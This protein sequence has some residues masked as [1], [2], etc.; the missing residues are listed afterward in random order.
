M[1]F[2]SV[3][4]II[5]ALYM[6]VTIYAGLAAKKYVENSDGYFVA[7][8]K[9]KLSLGIASLIASEIGIVTFMYFAEF[10]FTM[11]FSS[12]F[13]GF[14]SMI[15]F[16][17]IGYSGFIVKRLRQLRIM[18]VPE[19]YEIK[20]DKKVRLLGGVILFFSGILNMG[21]F[22][23]FD[24]LFLSEAMGLGP[25]A[26]ILIM[27]LM[28]VIVIAYTILGGML[29]VVITDFMQFVVITISMLVVTLIILNRVSFSDMVAAV[30]T[31]HGDGGFNPLVHPRLGW[32]F[33]GW[34]LIATL[35]TGSLHQPIAAKAF[36][37]ENS[38]VA[39]TKAFGGI[40]APRP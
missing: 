35:A 36:C 30:Q 23:K 21:I 38:R 29:S 31:Q 8:R 7:G 10:G 3:D 37:S 28:L 1:N 39:K 2:T 12:F 24:A 14:L 5:M 6:V 17:V 19:F 20:Y 18:T 9:V 16:M 4:A 15:G 13:V 26:L 27:I 40:P 32:Y 11:G 34:N 22:L 25:D 33:I